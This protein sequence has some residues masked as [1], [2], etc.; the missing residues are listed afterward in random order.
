MEYSALSPFIP[1]RS[2]RKR[3]IRYDRQRYRGRHL[4]ENACCRINDFRRVA[5]RCQRPV[6]HGARHSYRILALNESGP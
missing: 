5:T 4:I 3:A 1:V 6:R 2:N